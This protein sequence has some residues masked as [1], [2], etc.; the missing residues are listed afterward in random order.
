MCHMRKRVMFLWVL[1]FLNKGRQCLVYNPPLL[2]SATVWVGSWRPL[3]HASAD[4][5]EQAYYAPWHFFLH[6]RASCFYVP[7]LTSHLLSKKNS[8][9][10]HLFANASSFRHFNA[11]IC[12]LFHLLPSNRMRCRL[13][14]TSSFE[15]YS[16]MW[17][18]GHQLKLS[19]KW[20]HDK[21]AVL[22]F[23]KLMCK[24]WRTNP[25]L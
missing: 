6:F 19:C 21:V 8:H 1:F 23:Y 17:I 7:F 24:A 10:P 20:R 18:H 11:A 16:F 15:S 14:N 13:W 4:H 2:S 12:N 22:P 9:I 25:T 5:L 3:S